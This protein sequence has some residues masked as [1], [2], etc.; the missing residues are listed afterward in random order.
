M[1]F[2]ALIPAAIQG[3]SALVGGR[4]AKKAAKQISEATT[5]QAGETRA[6]GEKVVGRMEDMYGKGVEGFEPYAQAG[7]GGL[8]SLSDFLTTGGGAQ[9]FKFD[10][11]SAAIDPSYKFRFDQGAQAIE[12]SRLAR[13]LASGGTLKALTDYGQQSASQ[14]YQNMFNRA[15]TEYGTNQDVYNRLM[16]LTGLG[17]GAA[18]EIA[19]LGSQFGQQAGTIDMATQEMINNLLLQGAGAKASGTMGAGNAWQQALGGVSNAVGSQV[20]YNRLKD[21]LGMQAGGGGTGGQFSGL[22]QFAPN[23]PASIPADLF[24]RPIG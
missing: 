16:G 15:F 22:S 3:I 20:S 12:R 14:E 2:A 13:G 23:V 7:Q 19:G 10:P 11:A 1:P 21:L 24:T 5:K 4:S 6:T 18:G 17:F 9:P 8:A